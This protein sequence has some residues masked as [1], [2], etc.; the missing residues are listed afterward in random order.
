MLV[1]VVELLLQYYDTLV[2]IVVSLQLLSLYV[3]R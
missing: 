1:T 2:Q 3:V